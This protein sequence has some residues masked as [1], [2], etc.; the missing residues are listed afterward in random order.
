MFHAWSISNCVSYCEQILCNCT[1]Q[2][3][4]GKAVTVGVPSASW[5]DIDRMQKP[6]L[7]D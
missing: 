5:D 3:C 4:I 6:Q 2:A 7:I 1:E